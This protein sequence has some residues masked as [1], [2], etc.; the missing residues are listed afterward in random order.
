MTNSRIK[1]KI[2]IVDDIP[3]NIKIL[4]NI[5]EDNYD[6]SAVTNGPDAIESLAISK[7]PD[8][9]LLDIVMP[10]MDG[11]EVCRRLK[12]NAETK[13][14]LVIFI[15]ASHDAQEEALGLTLGAVDF[16][17][18]GAIDIIL[19]PFIPLIVRTRIQTH[20]KL[21]GQQEEN[22]R[23]FEVHNIINQILFLSFSRFSMPQLL[24]ETL[25]SILSVSW[26]TTCGKGA[27]FL[28]GEENEELILATHLN[29]P[30]EQVKKCLPTTPGHCFCRRVISSAT[31]GNCM[32]R[33]ATLEKRIIFTDDTD[34]WYDIHSDSIQPHGLYTVPL[35]LGDKILGVLTLCVEKGHIRSSEKDLFLHMFALNLANIIKQKKNQ[36]ETNH[37]NEVLK[38]AKEQAESANLAKS[39]FLAN[40]SHEIRSPMNAIIGMTDLILNNQLSKQEEQENLR[41]VQSSSLTLLDLIN[42]ILDLSKIEAGALTLEKIP[43]DLCGQV[44]KACETMA[45][46]AHQKGLDLSCYVE[47][48]LP[49]TLVG[50]PLRLKQILINLISNAIK[51]TETG[52]VFVSVE[53][54]SPQKQNEKDIELYFSVVDTGIGIPQNKLDLIFENFSQVDGSITRKHGGTGLG[55]TICKHLTKMMN[56]R[57]EVESSEGEGSS[58][59]FNTQF[60][61]GQ[62]SIEGES[63]RK[64]EERDGKSLLTSTRLSG[65]R[66][67]SG[68]ARTTSRLIVKE[69]INGFGGMIEEAENGAILLAKLDQAKAFGQPF[70]VLLLEN[71]LL[72]EDFPDTALL[73]G[74][75]GY[76]GKKIILL[77]T[78]L[79][80]ETLINQHPWLE[81][82]AISQKPVR[83]FPL[84]RRIEQVL[85]RLP[86]DERGKSEQVTKLRTT[87][88]PLQVLL[89]EDSLNNQKL[90][91]TILR[92]AGHNITI[93]NHGKEALTLLQKKQVVFDLILM[94]LQMP[95]MDGYEATKAIRQAIPDQII[96]PQ[97]PIIAVTANTLLSEEK[98]CLNIGMNGYL[99]KP[100]RA[101]E[102]LNIVELY[103]KPKRQKKQ[104]VAILQ[105]VES[106]EET[107]K[108][109]KTLFLKETAQQMKNLQNAVENQ[110]INQVIQITGQLTKT[111]RTIGAIRVASQTNRLKGS[112]EMKEWEDTLSIFS[113]LEKKVEQVL[114]V[115][116][117]KE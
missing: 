113:K 52:S 38:A 9:I 31:P 104:Q 90:A 33:R 2:L 13:D 67:L 64:Q 83:R 18:L 17:A 60:K 7:H 23:L 14:I 109:R 24:H 101:Y 27:I 88:I 48:S 76:T 75:P 12:A 35:Q 55:L 84:V 50:D 94:D 46:K 79:N 36:E 107:L 114:E 16:L 29:F 45:I 95:I 87:T 47:W 62:R 71:N 99:C 49:E 43:F 65:I 25:S 97:T 30:A 85:G 66:V 80:L 1:P 96:N 86:T 69:I 41:I 72:T 20:L 34:N 26:L 111:A 10:D 44:E 115:L 112:A 110:D 59:Q 93:A 74:H 21:K 82:T 103:A 11:F 102:L 15:T 39:H 81:G 68:F 77:P 100:Y 98:T 19:K 40:M 73:D 108:L 32:C 91:T 70:D 89:V 105:P 57:L 58:F 3:A 51:F 78:N 92:Q 54:A 117:E 28:I 56:G 6:V 8:L 5:L 4:T 61:V 53:R 116:M 37:L 42:G 22:N 63:V 106:D